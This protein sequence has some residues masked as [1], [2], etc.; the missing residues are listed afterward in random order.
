MR[1]H[2]WRGVA[3]LVLALAIVAT[4]CSDDDDDSSDATTATTAAGTATTAAGG[5]GTATTAAGAE[6]TVIP[7][8]D[9]NGDGEVVLA[10]MSPGDVNDKGFY[11]GFVDAAKAVGDPAGWTITA[12]GSIPIA[13]AEAQ[14]RAICTKDPKPDMVAIG[15]GELKDALQL[16]QDPACQDEVWYLSGGAGEAQTP[17][18]TQATDDSDDVLYSAGVAA[19]ILMKT[20]DCKK[21]GFITGPEQDFTTQAFKGFKTG[22]LAQVADADVVA[23]YTTDLNAADVNVEAAKAQISQGVCMMYP[24]LG[25]GTFA[26]A[27]EA[28]KTQIPTLTPGS[29][30]CAIADPPFAISVLFGPGLYFTESLK[31]F[32]AGTFQEGITR[33][34]Q[35]GVDAVPTVKFC[36]PTGTQQQDLDKVMADIGSGALDPNALVAAAE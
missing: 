15:A 4:A 9:V 33:K 29:D 3:G 1:H 19:G 26:V 14:A 30:N 27:S 36:Q 17:F 12:T 23:T 31:A 25:G 35:L 32:E 18:F 24:Y 21:A 16:S 20:N 10:I 5:T 6:G 13:D 2:R 11:Q 7:D 8:A 28:A 34:F 22:V